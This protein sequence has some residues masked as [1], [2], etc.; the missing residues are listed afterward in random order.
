MEH[1][2]KCT[3]TNIRKDGKVNG[4]QR[5]L[6]K[7]CTYHFSVM[8]IGKPSKL[9][10]DAIKLYLEGLGFRAIGRF[11]GV[12]HVSVFNWV[13]DAGTKLDN[14]E[15]SSEIAVIELD[16]MHSYIGTKKYCWLWIAV[17]RHGHR[18][19]DCQLGSRGTAI[20]EQLWN[21]IK[22]KAKGKVCTDY[23]K[24]YAEFIPAAI[25]IQSKEE[26]YTVEGY[27]SLFR[28]YLARMKRKTKCYS[29]AYYMLLLSVKLLM[30]KWNILKPIIN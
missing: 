12:S 8:H 11:L 6:C 30:N 7:D 2:P 29:K 10:E 24:S 22:E 4:K 16:E 17:D 15:S 5:W 14:L 23:W 28:H 27:N 19:I 9:K 3:S 13:K 26:T 1:C 21:R 25:H 20:G 18:F